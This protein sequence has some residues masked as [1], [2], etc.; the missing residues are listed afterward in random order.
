MRIQ[1]IG[2]PLAAAAI[3][4][5]FT[6]CDTW[7]PEKTVTAP[8]DDPAL[9]ATIRS[10][11]PVVLN[12]RI[13]GDLIPFACSSDGQFTGPLDI[14]MTAAHD[15]DL[16]EV[17]IRLVRL[18][19]PAASTNRFDEDD[20]AEAN[21]STKIPGGTVRTLRFRTRLACGRQVPESVAADIR[22]EEFSGRKNSIT[23]SALLV[24]DIGNPNTRG[25]KG[26]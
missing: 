14:T 12:T 13:V 18:G 19:E 17:I 7:G 22:F 10:P 15:V 20:L 26:E 5:A 1:T 9:I 16:D 8:T 2:C 3:T 25:K 21:G 4:I 23:A 24:S 11:T 6:A